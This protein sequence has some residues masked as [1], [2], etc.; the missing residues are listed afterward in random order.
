MRQSV[1]Y[2]VQLVA[3]LVLRAALSSYG[4]RRLGSLARWLRRWVLRRPRGAR[5]ILPAEGKLHVVSLLFVSLG[6]LLVTALFWTWRGYDGLLLRLRIIPAALTFIGL[7]LRLVITLLR[8]RL[9]AGAVFQARH[10]AQVRLDT[11]QADE[12]DNAQHEQE[13]ESDDEG[14][15]RLLHTL[16]LLITLRYLTAGSTD[17]TFLILSVRYLIA[18]HTICTLT[19]LRGIYS[20]LRPECD[21]FIACRLFGTITSGRL[22]P[23]F[24]SINWIRVRF[25]ICLVWIDVIMLR[26]ARASES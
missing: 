5:G 9:E 16:F 7:W 21:F 24:V 17:K 18:Q 2:L 13:D 11:V 19:I 6:A 25:I 23:S 12:R 22:G 26:C 1:N 8:W 4:C 20:I 3:A 14:R 15:G 10:L